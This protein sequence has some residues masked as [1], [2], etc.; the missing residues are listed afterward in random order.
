MATYMRRDTGTIFMIIFGVLSLAIGPIAFALSIL[1]RGGYT[2]ELLMILDTIAF[3]EVSVIELYLIYYMLRSV[4]LYSYIDDDFVCIKFPIK[5]LKICKVSD[6]RCVKC[7]DSIRLRS[8]ILNTKCVG[9]KGAF[10]ISVKCEDFE[11]LGKCYIYINRTR[12]LL[13]LVLR[14]GS[15]YI[16]SPRDIDMFLMELKARNPHLVYE[17]L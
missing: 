8:I 2:N 14:D 7:I 11:D 5:V 17:C 6:V 4:A 13:L 10:S 3:I 15:K 16:I 12:D 1:V 9:N